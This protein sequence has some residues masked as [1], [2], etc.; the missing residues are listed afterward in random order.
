MGFHLALLPLYAYRCIQIGEVRDT[1]L[2]DWIP[3]LAKSLGLSR[4]EK[5]KVGLVICVN[6]HHQLNIRPI[7][8]S[9]ISVPFI[10]KFVISPCPLLFSRRDVVVSDVYNS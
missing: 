5:R 9:Q 8:I 1:Y 7:G 2:A 4:R 10:S 6:A 3:V